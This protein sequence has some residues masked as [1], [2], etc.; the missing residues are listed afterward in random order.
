MTIKKALTAVLATLALSVVAN[1]QSVP[2]KLGEEAT[3]L[4][5][6]NV[7]ALRER[8]CGGE[9][10]EGNQDPKNVKFLGCLIYL[11]LDLQ[12][13]AIDRN[14]TFPCAGEPEHLLN[15][16][17]NRLRFQRVTRPAPEGSSQPPWIARTPQTRKRETGVGRA[18]GGVGV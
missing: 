16:I 17:V 13:I 3:N 5:S 12:V 15:C 2:F 4:Y 18:A 10:T 8:L 7:M 9:A 14:V 11:L 1:A 6:M